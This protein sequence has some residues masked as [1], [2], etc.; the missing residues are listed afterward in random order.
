MDSITTI[1]S[2]SEVR[3]CITLFSNFQYYIY[4]YFSILIYFFK[5]ALF[6]VCLILS[7]HQ[8]DHEVD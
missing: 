6:A 5:S 4:L 7:I 2:Q 8:T 1:V 3:V